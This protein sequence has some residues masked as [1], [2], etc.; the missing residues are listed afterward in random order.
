MMGERII[1]RQR[2]EINFLVTGF[3]RSGGLR[4]VNA[5]STCEMPALTFMDQFNNTM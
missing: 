2:R 1:P 4:R 3:V 5:E